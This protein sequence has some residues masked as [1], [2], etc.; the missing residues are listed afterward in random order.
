VIPVNAEPSS[1]VGLCVPNVTADAHDEIAELR[2]RLAQRDAQI[3]DYEQRLAMLAQHVARIRELE[4]QIELLAKQLE[5]AGADKATLEARL[6]ELLARRRAIG[7]DAAGQLVLAFFGEAPLPAPPC[8]KEAPDGETAQDDLR[9]RHVRKHAPRKLAYEALPR[10]HVQHELPLAERICKITGKELVIVGEKT[11]E[12]LEYSPAKLVVVVHH[13]AL[14][15][16]NEKD[17]AERTVEPVEAPGPVQPIE[18]AK[19]GPSL[20][21][22]ILVQKYCHHLP[23]YR[24]QAIFEREGLFLP[25][26]TM[27]DWVMECAFQLEPIQRAMMTRIVNSGVVQLDDT[28]VK[29]QGPPGE[30]VFEARLWTYL[31][32][33]DPC[34]VFDFAIDR[35]HEHVLEF[36]GPEI[37]GYLVGDGYSGYGTI[38]N[39]RKKIIEAGCW[40]HVLRKCREAIEESPVEA[41]AL[42]AMIRTLF[43]IE[44]EAA[45]KELAPEAVK[46][47]RE[48]RSKPALERIRGYVRAVRERP[49]K[50]SFESTTHKALIYIEN[51]WDALIAFLGDGRVPIHN[52]A[53]ERSI[54]PVA[55]GRKNWLFAGSERGGRAAATIYS[56]IESCKRVDVDAFQY[57][58]DVLVRVAT[59]PADRVD[60]LAP[61]RWKVLFAAKTAS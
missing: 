32:P 42:V 33:I 49:E 6:K 56:I 4:A 18:D 25:R 19:A 1:A 5:T 23:L 28:P 3:S 30:A 45:E 36:L 37:Q 27:C 34:V 26:Q 57:F 54:R 38:A 47:L 60:E 40:A 53:S 22:W 58:R 43:E 61:D 2:E 59:H 31:S 55:I 41:S 12:Q 52:N 8:A 48:E 21:A 14:Y 29:C 13:R 16:L 17:R 7:Q 39:K 11:S 20:L 24:Q 15:G 44:A 35:G 9:P 46:A 50:L 51:Q 10:E